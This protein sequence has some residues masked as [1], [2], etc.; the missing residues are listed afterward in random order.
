[1]FSVV[2]IFLIFLFKAEMGPFSLASSNRCSAG[3]VM[4]LLHLGYSVPG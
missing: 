3:G 2:D 1:M 4:I